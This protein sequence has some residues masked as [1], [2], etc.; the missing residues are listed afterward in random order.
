MANLCLEILKRGF[1]QCQISAGLFHTPKGAFVDVVFVF[2]L[3]DDLFDQILD[4]HK[5]INA[6]IFINH[7]R[8]MPPLCLHLGQQHANGHAGRHKQQWPQHI[9]HV[10]IG[11]FA[12]E[13]VL[14][15][16]ILEVGHTHRRVQRTVI[17]R[18]TGQAAV[19]ENLDQLFQGNRD[20]HSGDFRFGHRHIIHPHPP[21]VH[22]ATSRD[23]VH[24]R[25]GHGVLDLAVGRAQRPD[26]P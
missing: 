23:P 26:H 11:G 20:R 21:Q 10:E 25:R 19:L 2:D 17:N 6:A 15:R 14:Q 9:A 1:G 22:H 4:C 24:R 16:Q 7:Q 3:A 8:H 12:V 5:T 13:P 18:Q